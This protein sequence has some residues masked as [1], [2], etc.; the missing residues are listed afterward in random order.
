M[1]R[2]I[3]YVLPAA[4]LLSCGGGEE[5]P[6]E[7][8]PGTDTAAV[9]IQY[10]PLMASADVA[11]QTVYTKMADVNAVEDK[12]TV[13]RFVSEEYNQP[14]PT[15]LLDAQNLQVLAL[16]NMTGEIPAEINTFKNL[17]TLV[18]SGDYTTLPET[19][20]ELANLKTVSFEYCKKLDLNQAIG[21][22]KNCPNLQYLNLSG[23]DLAELPASIGDLS[24][25]V[26]IRMSNNAFT[27]LPES[28]FALQNLSELRLGGPGLDY[29]AALTQAKAL[30]ALTTLWVQYAG[31][32]TLPKVLSEYPALTTVH[33]REEWAGKDSD[34]IIA[35]TDKETK[36][37]G[38]KITVTWDSMSGMYYDIY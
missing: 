26:E 17:T 9:A 11:T 38:G 6:T 16:T 35:T 21:V 12:S 3:Y 2:N 37:F 19:V 15:E 20:G 33:W 29:E 5:A 31:L 8:T 23:M 36:K 30:P 22:L 25:L 32:T 4:L 10:A 18:I 1:K 27:T 28:L 13:I 7:A 34:Q 14:F 24:G